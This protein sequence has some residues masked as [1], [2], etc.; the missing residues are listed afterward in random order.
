MSDTLKA[1]KKQANAG[2]FKK[3]QSG[4]PGGR[5][6]KTPELL[7]VEE[8]CRQLSPEAVRKMAHWMRTGDGPVS[9]K[10]ADA[11]V[12]RG[13][14]RPTE[15]KNVTITDER[16]VVRAPDKP[17]DTADWVGRHGPH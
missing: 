10:A 14:G 9:L 15:T 13:F 5:P 6:K 8:L 11:I 16:M 3:G 2:S 7:E 4:N 1:G 17:A 12:N